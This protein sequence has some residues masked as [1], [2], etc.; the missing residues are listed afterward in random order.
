[1]AGMNY[2]SNSSCTAP[3]YIMEFSTRLSFT[4]IQLPLSW[5]NELRVACP[6]VADGGG[7]RLRKDWNQE[8]ES[9]STAS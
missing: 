6:G 4:L 5:G 1:M 8:G 2:R 3:N 9:G 7:G